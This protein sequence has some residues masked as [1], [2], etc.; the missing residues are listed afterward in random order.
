MPFFLRVGHAVHFQQAFLDKPTALLP[1]LSTVVRTECSRNP[2]V[3]GSRETGSFFC[4]ILDRVVL[5]R[6]QRSMMQSIASS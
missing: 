4:Q 2:Y 1:L 5:S 3:C 6:Q